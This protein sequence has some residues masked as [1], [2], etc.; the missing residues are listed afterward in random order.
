M[1]N[2]MQLLMQGEAAEEVLRNEL[3]TTIGVLIDRLVLMGQ[4]EQ[5][6]PR[7]IA[8]TP[9]V[10][11]VL[12]GGAASWPV[13]L[14]NEQALALANADF[15]ADM[16]FAISPLTQARWKQIPRST[17]SSFFLME[18]QRVNGF[19]ALATNQLSDTNVSVFGNWADLWILI[20]GDG[21]DIIMNLYSL[22]TEARVI[23]TATIWFNLLIRHPQSFCV[24]ADA[25]NQCC[26]GKS[27]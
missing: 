23:V 27:V 3:R 16:G 11:S 14:Q 25:A 4:G 9:G 17:G 13:I 2:Y 22:A 10:G 26:F 7:G 18:D 1:R 21:V 24:S 6:Q 8:A 5:N 19:R 15:R 12:Y 20:W